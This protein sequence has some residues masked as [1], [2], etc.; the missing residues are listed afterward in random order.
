[1]LYIEPEKHKRIIL[2]DAISGNC[3]IIKTFWR[4]GKLHLGFSAPDTVKIKHLIAG[5]SNQEKCSGKENE[6]KK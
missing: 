2:T 4:Q 5:N 3:T 6:E 1:M